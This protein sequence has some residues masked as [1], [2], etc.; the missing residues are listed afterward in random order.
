MYLGID[1]SPLGKTSFACHRIYS[2]K[3]GPN[4]QLDDLKACLLLNDALKFMVQD[5]SDTF[6]LIAKMSLLVYSC[7]WLSWVIGLCFG[8]TIKMPFLM[9][10]Y[11][12]ILSSKNLACST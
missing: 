2:V 9:A 3:V 10:K 5:Y 7:P 8:W 4:G 12:R 11:T 6:S 1:S